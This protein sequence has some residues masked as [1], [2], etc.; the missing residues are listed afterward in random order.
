MEF[1]TR[2]WVRHENLNPSGNLFGGHLLSW[3]DEEAAIHAFLLIKGNAVTKRITDV[4]FL[5]PAVLGDIIEIGFNLVDVG[6]SSISFRCEAK[7]SRTGELILEIDKIVFVAVDSNG[8]PKRHGIPK[9][10]NTSRIVE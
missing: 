9:L 4:N 7:N 1:L 3:I 6:A 10:Q 8:K 5:K 2:R